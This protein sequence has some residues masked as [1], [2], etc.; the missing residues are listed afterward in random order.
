M[1]RAQETVAAVRVRL[2]EL[3]KQFEQDVAALDAAY[4]AQTEV[5]EELRV[6]PRSTDV[7]LALLGIGWFPYVESDDGRLRPA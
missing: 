4:D 2:A 3:E 1:R 5:L 7:H 6:N